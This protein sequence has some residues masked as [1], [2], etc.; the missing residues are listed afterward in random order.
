MLIF[1]FLGT[2]ILIGY[3]LL[4][5]ELISFLPSAHPTVPLMGM[6][7]KKVISR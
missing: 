1:Y 2:G 7:Y 4:L 3:V 5:G 6:Y